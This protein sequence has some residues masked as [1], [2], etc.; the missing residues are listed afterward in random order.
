M[1]LRFNLLGVIVAVILTE[2]GERGGGWRATVGE[3]IVL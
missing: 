3:S 2:A 1:F